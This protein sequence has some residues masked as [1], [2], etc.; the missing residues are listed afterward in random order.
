MEDFFALP[1]WGAHIWRGLYMEGLIFGILW[2]IYMDFF[3][4]IFS[5]SPSLY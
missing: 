5:S 2:Y 4:Q 3:G 1:V